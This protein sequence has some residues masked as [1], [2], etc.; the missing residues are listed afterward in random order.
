[1]EDYPRTLTELEQRFSTEEACGEYLFQLRWAEGFRCP[2]C[3]HS[4]AWKLKGDLFKCTACTHKT[5][6]I[7]GTL[8]EGTRKSLVLWFRV[9]WWITSQKNGASALGLQ[10][11]IGLGSYKTAWMW[12]HKLRRA[13]VR[14]GRDRLS[15]TVQV[16]ETYIGG[17]KPGKRGRGAEGKTLVLIA[18]QEDG[19]I[20][21]RIRLKQIADASA[22]SLEM[23]VQ[24]MVEPGTVVKTDGWK[25][26][27]GINSL[28]YKHRIIRKT[29]TI[30][31]N[32]LPLCHRE[33]SLIKRWLTGTHQGAVSHEH[34][35]YYLD[36]YTFRFNRRTSRYRG[37]LFYRLLQNA[38]ALDAVSYQDITKGVRG[39]KTPKHNI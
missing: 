32:L 10:H 16:D 35:G 31:D 12:L 1:M 26:Y 34:L 27:N 17:E 19:R 7:A 11:I 21:G 18:A 39:T 38:V 33:A 24:E 20:T 9:I 4:E 37:K 2:V 6:V 36:E 28:G 8:F 25:G 13:M 29:A 30:G 14:P 23:A 15:G 3:G 22:E 5:S